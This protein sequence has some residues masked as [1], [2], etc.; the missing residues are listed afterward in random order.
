VGTLLTASQLAPMLHLTPT[1]IR[2]IAAARSIGHRYGPGKKFLLFGHQDFK[3]L[4][5]VQ[6]KKMERH[7]KVRHQVVMQEVEPG[8]WGAFQ[9]SLQDY[10]IQRLDFFSLMFNDIDNALQNRITK[11]TDKIRL[12][13]HR[14]EE[15]VKRLEYPD[16]R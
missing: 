11:V 15:R 9:K 4:V 2:Q 3:L 1:R 13:V 14:L 5:E 7:I 12:D 6:R 16:S 8:D 10:L